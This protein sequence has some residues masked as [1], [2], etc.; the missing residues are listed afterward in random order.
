M[1]HKY[2]NLPV[3]IEAVQFTRNNFEE[4]KSFTNE[5]IQYLK[6]V[7][8]GKATINAGALFLH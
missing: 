7:A 1:I 8:E 5:Y 6:D 4:I 2:V 3:E